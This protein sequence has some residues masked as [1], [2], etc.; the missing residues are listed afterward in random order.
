M[1]GYVYYYCYAKTIGID[2]GDEGGAD[3]EG[4]QP[5]PPRVGN[6]TI[7]WN[8]IV[9]NGGKGITGEFGSVGPQPLRFRNGVT[10]EVGWQPCP[11]C[12]VH[13]N[14][15]GMIMHNIISGNNFLGCGAAE[16]AALKVHGFSGEVYVTFWPNFHHF[17]R[18]ELDLRGHM[19]VWGAALSCLRFKRADMV[20]I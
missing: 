6:H 7:R 16:N 2:I 13:R 11:E 10:G 8:R 20:L 15:G 4:D 5:M 1:W 17:D 18:F 12:E 9:D 3:P 14:R 19:H